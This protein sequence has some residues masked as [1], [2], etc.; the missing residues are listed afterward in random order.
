MFALSQLKRSA[1]GRALLVLLT[2]L[3]I[4]PCGAKDDQPNSTVTLAALTLLA[5]DISLTDEWAKIAKSRQVFL[6]SFRS[7]DQSLTQIASDT[8]R[9]TM[10]SQTNSAPNIVLRPWGSTDQ[11]TNFQP[12][13][14]GPVYWTGVP[15]KPPLPENLH[16]F[17]PTKYRT[18]ELLRLG[19]NS[20]Q[21]QLEFTDGKLFSAVEYGFEIAQHLRF[22][23][24][25]SFHESNST[26][27]IETFRRTI[28]SEDR[29]VT[30]N[31][32][33]GPSVKP[34]KI[35]FGL[36]PAKIFT[37]QP[38]GSPWETERLDSKFAYESQP[39]GESQKQTDLALDKRAQLDAKL[40]QSLVELRTLI[41]SK[42]FE[43]IH[44][45]TSG[46]IVKLDEANSLLRAWESYKHD[47]D[48]CPLNEF[49]AS[50]MNSS[51]L[52]RG[53]NVQVN[54]EGPFKLATMQSDQESQAILAMAHGL[55]HR[56]PASHRS[57]ALQ[58]IIVCL[59]SQ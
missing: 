26:S 7:I 18:A 42:Q 5:D 8:L 41:T 14:L 52:E 3:I 15:L 22:T 47:S 54:E 38:H 32:H 29:V 51:G 9:L 28:D 21:I 16:R 12:P 17:I 56:T 59:Q 40:T 27:A 10:G 31:V 23:M 24:V 50:L 53:I 37:S 6:E 19:T 34:N 57:K 1:K 36:F 11:E 33:L 30:Q 58:L 20:I 55:F 45:S 35:N 2:F 25:G 4:T 44:S 39:L 46:S 13:H 43:F 48:S 49:S